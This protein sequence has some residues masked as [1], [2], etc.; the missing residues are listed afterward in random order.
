MQL[1]YRFILIKSNFYWYRSFLL[2]GKKCIFSFYL[3]GRD[4]PV[5]VADNNEGK[6]FQRE[7]KNFIQGN[8]FE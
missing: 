1:N 6:Y 2:T 7:F 4:L 5:L 8:K 3:S